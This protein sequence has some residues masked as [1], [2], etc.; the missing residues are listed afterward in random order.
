MLNKPLSILILGCICL[1]WPLISW[2]GEVSPGDRFYIV[3]SYRYLPGG[4]DGDH[5]SGQ[6]MCGAR[7]NALSSDYR[8]YT[9][10]GAWRM[11][12]IADDREVAIDFGS[13]DVPGQCI[14][15]ADEY[16]VKADE[17]NNR[18]PGFKPGQTE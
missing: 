10:T 17:L 11:I 16:V 12:K 1:C 4:G 8:N 14:C 6:S 18:Q 7:C 13:L 2:A 9:A 3:S 15:I 5:L